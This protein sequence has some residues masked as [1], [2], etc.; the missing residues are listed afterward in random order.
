[1]PIA[2]PLTTL[3]EIS[4]PVLLAPMDV[5]AGSRLVAAVSG[6]GGFGILGGGYGERTWLERETAKL[7]SLS[8][9]FGIGFI[10]WSLAKRPELLDIALGA[11]PS[12]IMLSFGDPAPFANK[13]KSAGARLICQVQ[14]EAMA[15]QA[16]E[17]GAD[18]LIAQGTEAGGHGAS[19]TTVDLVP[20]IV[21]LAAGVPVVAAGG[22]ADGRGLA[23]MMMLGASGVLLGTRFYAS[24]EADGAEEAKRR[25]C[26][27][28]SGSTVRGI[29]FDLSRNNVWPAPFTGRCLVNDHARRW[30]GREVE[31]MQNVAGV[32][33][34]YAAAKAA[35]NFDVAAVIAGEAVGLIHDIPPAAEIVERIAIE[36]GQLLA[37][38][39][40]SVV[41]R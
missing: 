30:S 35:G 7:A 29:I 36:A 19:R 26:A 20:A 28:S 24:E 6:A 31:L 12:A 32:A 1:M 33:A 39:R 9:P 23:A 41:A 17:A 18:I 16:L 8:A 27:A 5:I 10:T 13:I 3:L 11:R 15:R 2:T 14:D 40:N 38:R 21:D 4:H 37:G 25:I 34:D 22:I